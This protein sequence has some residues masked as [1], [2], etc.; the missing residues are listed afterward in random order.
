MKVKVYDF[1]YCL[2]Q[3]SLFSEK[4]EI[5]DLDSKTTYCSDVSYYFLLEA[6]VA[7]T[8]YLAVEDM[9][10]WD[11]VDKHTTLMHAVLHVSKGL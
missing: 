11:I 4:V 5:G 6:E 3:K 7:L 1:F 2:V 8:L 10:L 9:F